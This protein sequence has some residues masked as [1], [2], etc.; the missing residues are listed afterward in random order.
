[1]ATLRFHVVPNAKENEVVGRHGVAIKVKLRAPA[2][3]GKANAALRSFLAEELNI[4]ESR[5][6]LASGQKSRE[7]LIRIDALSEED[8]RR[9]LL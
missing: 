7:K 1:M 4:S 2:V 6:T 8:V 5:I 9:R 3:E